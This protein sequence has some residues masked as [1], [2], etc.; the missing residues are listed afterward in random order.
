MSYMNKTSMLD[1]MLFEMPHDAPSFAIDLGRDAP[2]MVLQRL[3]HGLW[4]DYLAD[5]QRVLS[6][7][8]IEALPLGKY[9]LV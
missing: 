3:E 6:P 1:E 7:I 4:R 2:R 5:G 9:R 8:K